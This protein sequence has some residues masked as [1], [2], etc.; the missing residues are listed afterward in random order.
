[1]L[2]PDPPASLRPAPV[3]DPGDPGFMVGFATDGVCRVVYFAGEL[4]LLT[5]HVANRACLDGD[6]IDMV[7][8]LAATTFMDCC[9]Y[10]GLAA[11]RLVIEQRGGSL[12]LRNQAGQ[13]A[14]VLALLRTVVERPTLECAS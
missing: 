3:V 4:D 14:R 10:G 7:V 13:P 8:D 12:T 1:M 5:C 9:G 6:H 11:A 2:T